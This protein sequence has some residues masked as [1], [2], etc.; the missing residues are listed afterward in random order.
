MYYVYLN[1][2]QQT[3]I[4]EKEGALVAS[5]G[6]PTQR[7]PNPGKEALLAELGNQAAFDAICDLVAFANAAPD[8]LIENTRPKEP[9]SS[10]VSPAKI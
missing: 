1:I 2:A 4:I 7:F 10:V 8:V 5:H 3:I 6:L 9:A